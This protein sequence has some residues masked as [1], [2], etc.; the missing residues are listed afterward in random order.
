MNPRKKKHKAVDRL[1]ILLLSLTTTV[2]AQSFNSFQPVPERSDRDFKVEWS[3]GGPAILVDVQKDGRFVK[4]SRAFYMTVVHGK[5]RLTRLQVNPSTSPHCNPNVPGT[6]IDD[7]TTV[8][9]TVEG[10]KDHAVWLALMSRNVTF[11]SGVKFWH[12]GDTID[13]DTQ[14]ILVNDDRIPKIQ[15]SE[16][17]T[18]NTTRHPCD[19]RGCWDGRKWEQ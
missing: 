6:C 11:S 12:V 3:N 17:L 1:A 8:L 14:T 19:Y 13:L 18:A 4:E 5:G 2:Q 9:L 10:L 7:N 16:D 15:N